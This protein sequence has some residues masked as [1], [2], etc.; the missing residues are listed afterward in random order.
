M[1]QRSNPRTIICRFSD[2]IEE[3]LVDVKDN[4]IE[5]RKLFLQPQRCGIEL[6]IEGNCIMV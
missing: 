1:I 5:A 2:K 6:C 4:Q 3:S